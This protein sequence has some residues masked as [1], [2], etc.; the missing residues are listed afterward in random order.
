MLLAS[1]S[2][3]EE[4]VCYRASTF[5]VPHPQCLGSIPLEN[6]GNILK[7]GHYYYYD[8]NYIGVYL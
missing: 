7:L 5:F 4:F 3:F 1:G 2:S 6:Q 8:C